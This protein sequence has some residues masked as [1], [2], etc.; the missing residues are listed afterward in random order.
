L[1]QHVQSLSYLT[2]DKDVRQVRMNLSAAPAAAPQFQ[3]GL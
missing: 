2:L 1:E 3:E